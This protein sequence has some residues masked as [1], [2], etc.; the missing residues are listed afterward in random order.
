MGM[1]CMPSAV[2]AEHLLVTV[3]VFTDIR[4]I[5]AIFTKLCVVFAS[6]RQAASSAYKLYELYYCVCGFI[7]SDMCVCVCVYMC[8]KVKYELSYEFSATDFF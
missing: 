6:N 8:T 7:L 1:L 2:S 3:C 4:L 5:P